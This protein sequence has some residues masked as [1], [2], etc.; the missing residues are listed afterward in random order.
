MWN[1]GRVLSNALDVETGQWKAKASPTTWRLDGRIWSASN[2]N[3][4]FTFVTF[5]NLSWQA[6]RQRLSICLF[7]PPEYLQWPGLAQAE[8][9]EPTSP[10]ECPIWTVG[11]Q[12]L[13]PPPL[14]PTVLPGR[15]CNQ[16]ERRGE[17]CLGPGTPVWDTGPGGRVLTANPTLAPRSLLS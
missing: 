17:E 8:S 15:N 1:W 11:T 4:S 13:Q 14:S 9:Q 7:L 3:L 10:S 2:I 5:L 12:L 16:E 6:E